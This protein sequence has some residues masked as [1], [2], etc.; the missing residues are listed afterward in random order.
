MEEWWEE[1]REEKEYMYV[2]GEVSTDF[3]EDLR[4][5]YTGL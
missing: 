4:M 2:G 3:H 5:P 1:G